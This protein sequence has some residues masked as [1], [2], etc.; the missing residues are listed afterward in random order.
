MGRRK[1]KMEILMGRLAAAR[2]LSIIRDA[3]GLTQEDLGRA[4]GVDKKTIQRWEGGAVDAP[5]EG[6]RRLIAVLR[7]SPDQYDDLLLN[8]NA[9]YAD[10]LT[11]A[12]EWLNIEAQLGL[13]DLADDIPSEVEL[14]QLI[15]EARTDRSLRKILRSTWRYWRGE[16]AT[17]GAAEPPS[18]PRS[19]I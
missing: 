13:R 10:S 15:T 11:A 7:C 5:Y 16:R 4:V 8:P 17:G 12:G 14:E 6:V 3:R 1:A 9:T 2:Y 18:P 19:S